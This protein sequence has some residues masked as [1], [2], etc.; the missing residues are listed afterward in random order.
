MTTKLSVVVA[1]HDRPLRL[2]WLLNAL[3]EQTLDRSEW[4]VVVAHDSRGPETEALLRDHPLGRDGTLR[5]VR[6]TGAAASPGTNRNAAWPLA[7]AETVVFTD[8][9]CR[10]PPEWLE[11][12]LAATRRRA[13]RAPPPAPSDHERASAPR[14]R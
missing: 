6:L 4:E 13:S 1:S 8:D 14:A 9:D 7:E 5:H 3:E 10:P 11:R 12:M 2:R